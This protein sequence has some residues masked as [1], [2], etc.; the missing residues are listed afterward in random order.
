MSFKMGCVGLKCMVA[1]WSLIFAIGPFMANSQ[2]C[3]SEGITFSRQDQI[4]LFPTQY[5]QCHEISGGVIIEESDD[6]R[7]L[8]L[9]GLSQISLIGGFLEIRNNLDLITLEGLDNLSEV[10][11]RLTISGNESL[12]KMEALNQLISVGESIRISANSSLGKINTLNQLKI[13]RGDL[14]ISNNNVLSV[15]QGF[16][17]VLEIDGSLLISENRILADLK[18]FSNLRK[19][20]E[21][22]LI[23]ENPMLRDLSGLDQLNQVNSDLII[24]NNPKLLSLKG[25]QNLTSVGRYLQIVSN[26]QIQSLTDLDSLKSIGGLLQIYNNPLLQSLNGLGQIDHQSIDNLA[27]IDCPQLSDCGVTSICNFL[28]ASDDHHSI[29]KNKFG[30]NH[31]SEI[32]DQCARPGG[33]STPGLNVLLLFPNPTNGLVSVKGFEQEANLQVRDITGKLLIRKKLDSLI[34]DLSDLPSAAYLV[35]LISERRTIRRIIIKT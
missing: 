2:T 3:L 30:C 6:N 9:Q 7:I 35:E 12:V 19:I 22:L 14:S 27:I 23:R 21:N 8:N 24:E 29:S 5:P 32:L 17:D 25:L 10:R 16:S 20:Q 18:D 28:N 34:I 11:G 26:T 13:I 31:R 1:R 4:D 33:S 15:L